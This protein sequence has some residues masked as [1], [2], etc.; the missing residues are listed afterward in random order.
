MSLFFKLV[1]EL[2]HKHKSYYLRKIGRSYDPG[3]SRIVQAVLTDHEINKNN[4]HQKNYT[5][6][7][8]KKKK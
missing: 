1:Y 5:Q 7:K 8:I 4:Y 3:E 6:N 2:L